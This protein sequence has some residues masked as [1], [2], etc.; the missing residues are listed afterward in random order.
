MAMFGLFK[1]KE[2]TEEKA[3]QSV[4]AEEMRAFASQFLSEEMDILAVTGAGGFIGGRQ[5]GESLYSGG[6]VL[7]AWME[8]DGEEIHKGQ[9]RLLTKAD[10]TLVRYLQQRL[11]R[12]FIIKCK[13]RPHAEGKMFML[14]GLPEPGFDPDLKAL[15]LEQKKPVTTEVEGLGSFTLNRSV[16]V[17]QKEIDW[18]GSEVQLCIDPESDHGSCAATALNMLNDMAAWDEKTRAFAADKLLEQANEAAAEYEGEEITREEF[19]DCLGLENI[20]VAADG[21]FQFWFTDGGLFGGQFV[22]ISGSV[23]DGLTDAVMEG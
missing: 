13:V 19:M 14:V 7:T 15:L 11:P 1:K 4:Q 3:N 9:F 20:D 23:A 6:A 10:E 17:L 22:R 21:V 12:D 5:E 2:K 8:E 18:L 16:G